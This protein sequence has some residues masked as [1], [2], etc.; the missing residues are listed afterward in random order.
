MAKVGGSELELQV[1][2]GELRETIGMLRD[3]VRS[4]RD[5]FLK[6]NAK[7]LTASNSLLISKKTVRDARKRSRQAGLD[8]AKAASDTWLE[9]RY[10]LRPLIGSIQS[11]ADYLKKEV[12][13]KFDPTV[14]RRKSFKVEQTIS[15][16]DSQVY[17]Y[18]FYK[19]FRWTA[20][21]ETIMRSRAV[22]Y[23]RLSAEPT[24]SEELGLTLRFLP[25]TAWELTRLSFVADWIFSIGPWLGSLRFK[26]GII[27]LGNTVS[28]THHAEGTRTVSVRPFGEAI[29]APVALE[30]SV[31]TYEFSASKYRRRVNVEVPLTPLFRGSQGLNWLKAIDLAALTLQPLLKGIR[32]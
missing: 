9:M 2:F 25:E 4:L 29:N 3:P 13:R 30:G 21:Q 11:V 1:E 18:D 26:P 23:Y 17:I 15:R 19:F 22:V 32:R 12:D 27:I 20:Y 7:N 8:A 16:R 24:V 14:I 6:K 31:G 5:F 10:G 28:T